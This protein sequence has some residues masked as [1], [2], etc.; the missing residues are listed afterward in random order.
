MWIDLD[1]LTTKAANLEFAFKID[2][3]KIKEEEDKIMKHQKL[4]N[5]KIV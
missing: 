5:C 2:K 3:Y 1:G 4:N